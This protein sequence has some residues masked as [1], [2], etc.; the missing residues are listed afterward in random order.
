MLL[1]VMIS[2]LQLRR[3]SD[4]TRFLLE[5][6][7]R[8]M[9]LSKRMLD[10]AQNQ[11]TALLQKIII[12]SPAFDSLYNKAGREFDQALLEATATVHDLATLDS[13][14]LARD[15]Y[16]EVICNHVFSS[17]SKANTVWFSGVYKNSYQRLT[18]SIKNYSVVTESNLQHRAEQ[19]EGS[20]YRAI[21]PGILTLAVM[22]MIIGLFYFFID[23]YLAKPVVKIN[24]AL[25]LYIKA[26][27]P[28]E[29]KT[30]GNDEVAQL[31]SNIED[32]ITLYKQKKG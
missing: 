8:N 9:E 27:V 13:V 26:R 28:F 6:S 11:N 23:L 15:E 30:D 31:R 3:L 22:I 24:K 2:L 4:E 19:L 29:V 5:V 16:E 17:D 7:T 14:Y 12:G 32:L 10:A 1:A 21:T 25:D 20:A 18:S